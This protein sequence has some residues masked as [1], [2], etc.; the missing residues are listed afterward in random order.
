[1]T[2]NENKMAAK[3]YESPEAEELYITL[4]GVLLMSNEDGDDTGEDF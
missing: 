1:M 3:G 2:I 4:N